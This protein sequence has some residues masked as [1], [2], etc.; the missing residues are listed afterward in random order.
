MPIWICFPLCLL[1]I[2]CHGNSGRIPIYTLMDHQITVTPDDCEESFRV[3]L[4]I[5]E[6]QEQSNGKSLYFIHGSL[7]NS[8]FLKPLIRSIF[9]NYSD[10]VRRIYAIDLPGHGASDYQ[11]QCGNFGQLSINDYS[12]VN[13]KVLEE[14]RQT[15]GPVDVLAGH[16]LGGIIVQKMQ[17]SLLD[18]ETDLRIEFGIDDIALIASSLPRSVY[19]DLS[20]IVFSTGFELIR[21][22]TFDYDPLDIYLDCSSDV[23]LNVFFTNKDGKVVEGAPE[24]DERINNLMSQE[25]LTAGVLE[26]LFFRPYIKEGAFSGYRLA[27]IA[28]DQDIFFDVEEE[29]QLHKYLLG[30]EAVD[31]FFL[32]AGHQAI[33]TSLY[34]MPDSVDVAFDYFFH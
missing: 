2:G 12:Q 29:L 26:N 14:I 6:N 1:V 21:C 27:T 25:S 8:N 23:V 33:H 31:G 11:D 32:V 13:L 34:T 3:H 18:C 16:S 15:Y 22:T 30:N 9:N 20:K 17:Q 10:H 19:L 4:L 24:T 5:A 7:C 28:Y